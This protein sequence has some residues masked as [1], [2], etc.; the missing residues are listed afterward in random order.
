MWCLHTSALPCALLREQWWVVAVVTERVWLR[1]ASVYVREAEAA[2]MDLH[3]RHG[4]P[5]AGGVAIARGRAPHTDNTAGTEPAT[6]G[7]PPASQPEPAATTSVVDFVRR[8]RPISATAKAATDRYRLK[9]DQDAGTGAASAS[10]PAAA[11]FVVGPES[12]LTSEGNNRRRQAFPDDA[13]NAWRSDGG[14]SEHGSVGLP[15]PQRT[16]PLPEPTSHPG[17]VVVCSCWMPLR[18]S[19]MLSL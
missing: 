13:L 14:V 15:N 9:V 1:Y 8:R 7:A 18:L 12:P 2:E 16:Q 4:T 17:C 19:S 11:R 10:R 5:P 6:T 3:R